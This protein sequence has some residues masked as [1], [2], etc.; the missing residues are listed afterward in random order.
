M[1]IVIFYQILFI[2][3]LVITFFI[4]VKKDKVMKE[5][6]IFLPIFSFWIGMLVNAILLMKNN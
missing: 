5:I 3:T 2:I 6:W 4:Y 1:D